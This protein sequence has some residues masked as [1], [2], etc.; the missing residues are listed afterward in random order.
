MSDDRR[1]DATI[2]R[3]AARV[4]V[5]LGQL[6]IAV[7]VGTAL[8]ALLDRGS[9]API[10][11]LAWLV[12]T[13]VGLILLGFAATVLAPAAGGPAVSLASPVGGAW[14]AVNSPTD[15]IPSH[16]THGFGQTYAVDLLIAPAVAD[17]GA[18][19]PADADADADAGRAPRDPAAYP[20]FGRPVHA[21]A[22]AEVVR[23]VSGAR[24]HG[25]RSGPLGMLLFG[26]EGMVREFRGT[27]GM[28]GNHVVLRLADG[29][30]F[31]LA[32]LRHG[33]VRVAP[34]QRVCRR[35]VLAECGN[36]GNSTE[37]HLHCQRQD[38][39]RTSA[40]MGLPWTIE[41]GGIPAAGAALGTSP[42]PDDRA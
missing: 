24:D 23:A 39:A 35:D 2:A 9:D 7:L 16:G 28:L 42:S 8:W 37:P 1:A 41:P 22:D 3:V 13:G 4:R 26:L 11:A 19:A 30:H 20:S 34:G 36:T 25:C 15:R 12:P 10:V 32:H 29:S 40:A 27:R 17:G 14:T 6:G 38:I 5:P 31:V 18:S 21:P 33:S